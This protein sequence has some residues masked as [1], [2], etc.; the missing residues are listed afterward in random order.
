MRYLSCSSVQYHQIGSGVLRYSW[1]MRHGLR[2]S[3]FLIIFFRAGSL[4]FLLSF[5]VPVL[6][7]YNMFTKP[8]KSVFYL[9]AM[10]EKV[11]VRPF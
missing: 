2:F 3:I 4:F 11:L 7:P 6:A 1:D 9:Y 8:T 5:D 10:E